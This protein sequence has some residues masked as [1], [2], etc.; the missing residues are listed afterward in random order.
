[1]RLGRHERRTI[2]PKG[3]WPH[4]RWLCQGTTLVVP[5][6][7]AKGR[8]ALAPAEKHNSLSTFSQR[9]KPVFIMATYGTNGIRT[10]PCR[11]LHFVIFRGLHRMHWLITN[12][13]HFV[14]PLVLLTSACTMHIG[15]I[16]QKRAKGDLS[17]NTTALSLEQ[18][19]SL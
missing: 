14:V 5:Q 19:S 10:R 13:E 11:M 17:K 8:W 9:L 16:G 3:S 6:A 15:W 4:R 2:C 7:I 1:M 18:Q 12:S